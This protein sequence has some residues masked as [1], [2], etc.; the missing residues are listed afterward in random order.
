MA[1]SLKFD[2]QTPEAEIRG[3]VTDYFND[4]KHSFRF[5]I[6]KWTLE[7]FGFIYMDITKN[8]PIEGAKDLNNGW[9]A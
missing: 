8:S 1:K 3:M 6:S 2:S 5:A 4:N 9:Y 7:T